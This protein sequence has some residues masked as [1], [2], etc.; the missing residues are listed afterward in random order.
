M[1]D[2]LKILKP[3]GGARGAPSP[4]VI[5]ERG[6]QA[7]FVY[8]KRVGRWRRRARLLNALRGRRGLALENARNAIA[9]RLITCSK[10]R[11]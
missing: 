4:L 6:H 1:I 8:S 10:W 3:R 5:G 11:S 7:N 9:R 2:S